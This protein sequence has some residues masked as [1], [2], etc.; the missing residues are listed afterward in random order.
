MTRCE[1]LLNEQYQRVKEVIEYLPS[2][3]VLENIKEGQEQ[4]MKMWLQV[5]KQNSMVESEK[6]GYSES[7][8]MGDSYLNMYALPCS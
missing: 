2:T 8:K 6:E 5:K 7:I 4:G 1:E 3:D